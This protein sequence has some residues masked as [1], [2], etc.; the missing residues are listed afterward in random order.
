MRISLNNIRDIERYIDGTMERN[1]ALLFEEKLRSDSLLKLN[2]L[3]QEKVLAIVRMYHRKKLKM[4]LEELHQRIFNDPGKVMFRER[5]MGIF[6][7]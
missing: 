6:R 4:E 2:V 1:D 7:K 5:V 3:L